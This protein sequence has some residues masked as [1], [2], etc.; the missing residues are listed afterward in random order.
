[1]TS[2]LTDNLKKISECVRPLSNYLLVQRLDYEHPFLAVVG[3]TLHKGVVVATGP[4]QRVRRKVRFNLCESQLSTQRA[5]YF[6]DGDETGAVRPMQYKVG[7][8]V[9]FSPRNQ[10]EWEFMG[11]KLLFIRSKAC[12]GTSSEEA[13][14]GLM[15]QQ[16]AGYDKNGNWLG[17][18]P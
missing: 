14:K 11:E 10:I 7:D 18:S 6:E 15:W 9:E 5:L 8:I 3:I 12:Y 4:G 1:L 13:D 2:Y 16:S 17:A